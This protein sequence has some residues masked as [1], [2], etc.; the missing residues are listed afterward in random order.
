MS[1]M[2]LIHSSTLEIW[3]IQVGIERACMV[4]YLFLVHHCN[5]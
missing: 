1:H 2:A 3:I 5:P 4:E